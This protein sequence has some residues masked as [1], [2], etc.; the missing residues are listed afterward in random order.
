MA[1][2]PSTPRP[3]PTRP[4]TAIDAITGQVDVLGPQPDNQSAG[5]GGQTDPDFGYGDQM[6]LAVFDGQVY[7]S[8]GG[9][10]QSEPPSS[11]ARSSAIR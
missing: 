2:I 3:T 8:L 11:T 9:Q 5:N 7:P 6:G 1:A 10:L 4:Q